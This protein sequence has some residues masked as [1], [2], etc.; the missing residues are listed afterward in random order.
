MSGKPSLLRLTLGL[1]LAAGLL[2][3]GLSQADEE[4]LTY[5]GKR[6][7]GKGKQIVFVTGD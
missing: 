6:G 1:L 7:P 5:L 3:P 4:W 2:S